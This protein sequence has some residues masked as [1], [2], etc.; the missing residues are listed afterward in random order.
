MLSIMKKL[1]LLL[2]LF[3]VISSFAQN[4]TLWLKS[5]EQ[6]LITKSKLKKNINIKEYSIFKLDL[7]TLKNQLIGTNLRGENDRNSNIIISLPNA[8][9]K[10]ENFKV[11]ETPIMETELA[12]KFP[13]IKS[14]AAQGIDDPTAVARFS[15]T[16]F[17]LHCMTLSGKKSTVYID[18]YTEDR[19]NYI[20]YDRTSISEFQSDFS[21]L[22]EDGIRLPSISIENENIANRNT[23]D[24]KL[25]T[26]RL[27]QSCTGEYGTIFKGTGTVA[28]QKA[29]VQAQMAITMTRVNG[30]YEKDLAITMIF[31]ANND[32]IIYLDA[33][34]DPWTS[35]WNTKTAQTIDAQIGVANYDIGHNF[36]TTGGGNAG[37]I[38][39]V[40]TSTSQSGTHKGR[41][42]TGRAN[43]TGDAFDIDYVAHEMGHQFGGYH[44]QSNNSCRSGNGATEVETGSGSTIMGYAGICAANVQSNSD[45]Y[46]GY[47]NI[48]DI[49]LNVKS[50]V[51]SSCAQITNFANNP[52]TVNAGL[53]YTIP[54]STPFILSA[55]GSDPDLDILT[56]C[57]EE[58]D[59]EAVLPSTQ[60]NAAPTA[61]RT[62]GPMFRTL[63][64]VT[65]TSRY[66]P[67]LTTVL[68]G[69]TSNTWEV[70]PSVARVL[71][72]SVTAR[73]N[74]A[75]GGQ[76]AS[77]LMVVTVNATA[78]PFIITA[79]NTAVSW[80]AGSNEDVIWNV[81][82]TTTNGVNCNY[83]DIYLSN[84]GGLTFPTLLASK[85]PNDGT[86]TITVPNT[87]GI[88]N[89]IMVRG[90]K[91][92]FYDVSNTNFTI[93]AAISPTFSLAFSGIENSQNK[94]ICQSV[95]ASY[96]LNYSTLLGFS[97]NT[98]FSVAGNPASSIATFSP[99]TINTDGIVN[100][101][102]SN[103]Q[104]CTPG[105]YMMTVT[106]TSGAITKTVKLY[107]EILNSNFAVMSLTS[108]VNLAY[109]Q[110]TN[111]TLNWV[112]DVAATLYDIQVA[113]DESFT[114]I[115][116][117]VTVGTNSY[118][119]T[120]LL[121]NANYFWK[122]MPKNSGCSGIF[123][124][125][126][127]F[128]TGQIACTS[129][130]S[131]N[132]PLAISASGTP[133]INSTLTIPAGSN[134]T[135]T[136]VNITAQIT[137]TWTA[138][139]VLT[140]ISPLGTQVQLVSGQ[141]AD[142]DNINATFDDLGTTLVC[143]VNPAITGTIKS[144]Q[145]LSLLNGQ[146]SQGDWTLRVFDNANGDGGTLT[147][148]SLNICTIPNIPVTCGQI[149]TN[150]NGSSWSNG[151]PVDNVAVTISGNYSSTEN[152]DACSMTVNNNAIVSIAS[153]NNI[154][155]SGALTVSSGSL[156][157]NNNSNLIQT[158]DVANSGNI[159]IKRATAL[160]MF[161][162][163]V[164]WSTPVLGQQLQSFSPLTLSN[165]FYTYNP[166]SNIY[167]AISPSTN[168][169]NIG[170]GYLIRM[171]NNHPVTP[172]S[173]MGTFTGVPNNGAI[174]I[175]VAN[176]TYNAIG[177]PYPSTIDADTFIMDN[178]LIEALYFWRKT[179]NT[180]TTSYAT[181]TLAG[182]I[183][184]SGGDPLLLIPNGI[185]QVGQGFIA[186][187]TSTSF[188]FTNLM[189][190]TNNSNQFLRSIEN[191]NRVWL[192]LTNSNGYF[193]QMMIAYMPIATI[194][195]DAAI[196]G[197]FFND[198]QTALTSLINNEEFSIQGRALP[199]ENTDIVALS[200][201]SETADNYTIS[202]NHFDGLFEETGQDI[203][204]K[205]NLTNTIH[206]LRISNYDFYTESG[207][208][209]SRFELVYQNSILNT[210]SN[211]II[212]TNVFVSTKNNS[213]T[214]KSNSI[215]L[216]KVIVYDVLGRVLFN[217]NQVNNNQ[218]EIRNITAKNQTLILKIVLNNGQ[219]VTRKIVI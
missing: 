53:D 61:I 174:G 211:E 168:D 30:V 28:Q 48:R 11:V 32:L 97:A 156:T 192:D 209:N 146:S 166:S 60:N 212:D 124:T 206:D 1:L 36:N 75:G 127:R 81:A 45:A 142:N 107:L 191:K 207:I 76:T 152:I 112:A 84:D 125:T 12:R 165:R 193:G 215:N 94:A 139:L 18:P 67:N 31:V 218:L 137:H 5:N 179:N 42:Y 98:T 106:G 126:Y 205:D 176:N 130:S 71:N 43:P 187:S 138:D 160:L 63:T 102:I 80:S 121:E 159:I 92:I 69:L 132:I 144:T 201:K 86:E 163:Y 184:N 95:S 52:P 66:F 199:F 82:G 9:G 136:D 89:R 4:K 143:G 140:L 17:G 40:C 2:V 158:T 59:P 104:L 33:A 147:S 122:V 44:T 200:F 99:I 96:D 24:K 185:I 151:K 204:L 129:F 56:Y 22:L 19:E 50:G 88:T 170:K 214:I 35:E 109:A 118:S 141:C 148:W 219:R 167:N 115:I 178:N 93:T 62:A 58:R 20:V 68:S 27:A 196:D 116:A 162:D 135:I 51:S 123:S 73:D 114:N 74:V 128:T 181:Y 189:R 41:G 16:Q 14:Y 202:I 119:Q 194:G 180:N 70:L 100:L 6:E 7:Q 83:V 47:V 103:T 210:T 79:P 3:S 186:K 117:N 149:I 108:P 87:L 183:S 111:L 39:C 15:I 190:V 37:C 49:L 91:H 172:T 64:G 195:V 23:D 150:W 157:L 216:D 145:L 188:N 198:S 173:F 164:L 161:Q 101:T 26:Y 153:G 78:G 177:N 134:V 169:F 131:T 175:P 90:N 54:K 154:K 77:D 213:I 34:T 105:F 113:T 29:N 208:Y 72:F 203:Y 21:C 85:V 197:R 25:R 217:V 155:L 46:F 57:W 65:S 182:G 8:D 120:G 55:T 13:M 133:T 110:S 171:P 38:G 10:L